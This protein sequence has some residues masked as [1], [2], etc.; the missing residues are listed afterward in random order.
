MPIPTPEYRNGEYVLDVDR[1][2]SIGK[3]RAFFGNFGVMVRAYAYILAMGSTGLQQTAETA[4]INANYIMAQ[5]QD[6]YHLL[7]R[8]CANMSASF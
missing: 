6:V 4:V 2:Q 8:P 5:L 1:P 7:I 3:V